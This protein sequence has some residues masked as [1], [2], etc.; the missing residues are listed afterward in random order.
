MHL[1]ELLKEIAPSRVQGSRAIDISDITYDSRQVRAG[2]AF[3]C[4]QGQRT[5]G[6]KFVTDAV[7]AGAPCIVYEGS[8]LETPPAG[9]TLVEVKNVRHALGTIANRLYNRPTLSLKLIGVTGTNGKTTTTYL[10]ESILRQAGL[11]TGLIGTI[12]HRFAGK[13]LKALHTTPESV[14]LL[15]LLR[16]MLDAGVTHVVM[17]VSSHGLSLGRVNACEFDI[18]LLTNITQDH[19]DFHGDLPAYVEAKEQLFRQMANSSKCRH[20]TAII[21]GDD[22]CS[23]SIIERLRQKGAI[24]HLL[25]GQSLG[26]DYR[27]EQTA[28][29]PIG[30]HTDIVG[31]NG[32]Q[33]IRSQL[34]GTHNLQNCIA[35]AAVTRE[36]GV[37]WQTIAQG[38]SCLKNVPGRLERLGTDA[39]VTVYIDFAHTDDALKNVLNAIETVRQNNQQGRG[40]IIT[41]FGCGGDRDRL[42]RPRMGH[43]AVS[44]S[45]LTVITSDNPRSEAPE[46]IIADIAADPQ[47]QTALRDCH[48]VTDKEFATTPVATIQP[49]RRQAIH[50]ALTMAKKND[51]VL[52]AGKGHEDYQEIHGIRHPFDD[53]GVAV[54][55]IEKMGWNLTSV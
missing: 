35:A 5:D 28:Y 54:E 25:F 30:F 3:A 9:V 31:P 17:E 7:N 8:L 24:K 4:I 20:A 38:I 14:D 2:A 23:Q 50:L 41:V 19:L 33:S 39:G 36:L 12:E 40:R 16:D 48:S 51:V 43:A 18:G 49:D 52:I 34:S 53:R 37:D 22:P 42:K 10:I 26:C 1:K 55:I 45:D 21:N 47:V 6:R 11:E 27:A 15:R 29:D 32:R 44:A 46:E 13:R